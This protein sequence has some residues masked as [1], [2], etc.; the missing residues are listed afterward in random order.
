MG[1]DDS[2]SPLRLG[3]STLRIWFML[4]DSVATATLLKIERLE[5]LG[6]L[7]SSLK[8]KARSSVTYGIGCYRSLLL[9]AQWV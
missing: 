2:R 7:R 8:F 1:W 9:A 6:L 4:L 3:A 5:Y